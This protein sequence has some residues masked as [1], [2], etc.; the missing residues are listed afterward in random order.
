[1]KGRGP[2]FPRNNKYESTRIL[3]QSRRRSL[4]VGLYVSCF[5]ASHKPISFPS[6]SLRFSASPHRYISTQN[7]P[8][9]I[10]KKFV[11][12]GFLY[13]HPAAILSAAKPTVATD[14]VRC[15][16]SSR[17]LSHI[18]VNK[19]HTVTQTSPSETDG[20]LTFTT[21]TLTD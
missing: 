19:A 14:T 15:V 8:V 1:M 2:S 13:P 11:T 21:G 12:L 10:T 17:E 9:N 20:I 3:I 5:P 16:S 4:Y 7:Q 6:L 18:S